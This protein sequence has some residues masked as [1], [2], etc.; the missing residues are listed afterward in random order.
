MNVA[1]AIKQQ[2]S[3][4]PKH[5]TQQEH[6][7]TYQNISPK[8]STAWISSGAL[9]SMENPLDTDSESGLAVNM[10]WNVAATPT[11]C[12]VNA[13]GRGMKD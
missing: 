12:V 6:S 9:L 4:S 3:D 2:A 8:R 7:Q 11:L 13:V 10:K 1:A 5:Q